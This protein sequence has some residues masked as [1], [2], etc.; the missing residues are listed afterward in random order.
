MKYKSR[1]SQRIVIAFFLMTLLISGLFSLGITSAITL[2]EKNLVSNELEKES[3]HLIDAWLQG[4]RIRLDADT[5]LYTSQDN[6]RPSYLDSVQEGYTEIVMANRAVYV[7]KQTVDDKVF[8]LIKDQS[9]FENQENL[10]KL[11]IFGGFISSICFSLLLGVFL[12]RTIIAPVRKLT[13]K[14]NDR[15][16]DTNNPSDIASGFAD[17]EVGELA[18][19]LDD[20]M[21]RLRQA[22]IRE[23]YFT[24]DISHELRTPLMVIRSSGELML[25]KGH[26]SQQTL[27]NIVTATREI[28]ELT[29]T[30]LCLARGKNAI[31]TKTQTLQAILQEQIPFWERQIT[32]KGIAFHYETLEKENRF[33]QLEFPVVLLKTITNNLLRNALHY[34]SEGCISIKLEPGALQVCDT[35]R[36]I[37]ESDKAM[38]FQ[39]FYQGAEHNPCG[40]GLGLSIVQ[41]I[42][43]AMQWKI[44]VSD[45]SPQGT[46]F[47]I[48]FAD[49]D[50]F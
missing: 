34:T 3:G 14:V 45:N 28:E 40:A 23:S 46:C 22:K 7:F 6:N 50:A 47:S 24:S 48:I 26:Y 17:D 10:I 43:E 19:V 11:A 15:K 4:Y 36:G 27:Q 18:S 41:R 35:G 8:Y 39:A 42:C 29:E 12:A 20:A 1:L 49:D 30:F 16:Y 33:F 13:E 32:N 9:E 2:V 37:P 5:L 21:N 25:E 38:I 44:R 31:T